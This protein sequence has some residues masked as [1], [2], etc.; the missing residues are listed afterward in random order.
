[1]KFT[2]TSGGLLYLHKLGF[3]FN[4]LLPNQLTANLRC[5]VFLGESGDHRDE[6]DEDED[7]QTD[8]DPNFFL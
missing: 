3:Y 1:M 8:G 5:L 4:V 6:D 2:G 7:G